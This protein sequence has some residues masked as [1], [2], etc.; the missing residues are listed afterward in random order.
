LFIV[1]EVVTFLFILGQSQGHTYYCTA[2]YFLPAQSLQA[3]RY[4]KSVGLNGCKLFRPI[5]IV[6]LTVGL[7][8]TVTTTTTTTKQQ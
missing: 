2:K 7:T 3:R 5:I 8:K 4:I 1:F 6:G